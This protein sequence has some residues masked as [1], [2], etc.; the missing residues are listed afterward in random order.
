MTGQPASSPDYSIL[1]AFQPVAARPRSSI[2]YLFSLLLVTLTMLLLPLIYLAMAGAAAYAVYYHATHNWSV[3]MNM[4]QDGGPLARLLMFLCYIV[5]VFAGAAMVFFILKPIFARRPQRAQPL[6]LNPADNPLLYA[7]IEK[8]CDS[9]GAPSP[10]RIDL[11]CRLNASVGFRRGF[12][13]MATDDLVLTIGLPFVAN[14]TAEE[15]TGVVAHEF[16][17]FNQR[18]GLRLSYL[19]R[20]V[21]IWFIRVVYQRDTWDEA[22][23]QWAEDADKIWVAALFW[24]VQIAVF[25]ERVVLSMLMY[26]GLLIGGFMLRQMEYD[27]DACQIRLVGSETF[28]RTHRK[29]AT[30]D[31]AA[32]QMG[33]QMRKLW[34][35]SRQLPD[36]ICE[37]LLQA[38][39]SLPGSVID[40]IEASYGLTRTSLFDS[41]PS[42]ADRVRRARQA[43][44][45]GA[46]HDDRPAS[47]L[48]TSFEHPARFVTMLHY[49]DELGIPVTPE[50]LV[51]VAAKGDD[52][53]A[54]RRQTSLT[55]SESQSAYFLGVLPLILP[56]KVALPPPSA[57]Y[58]ADF[59]ELTQLTSGLLQVTD[60][61]AGIGEQY[62]Q[63]TQQLIQAR[64]AVRLLAARVPIKADD[65]GLTATTLE[66]AQQLE[67]EALATRDSLRHSV[68]EVSAALQRRLR[69]GLALKLAD[70]GE[71][72]GDG[73]AAE[74]VA[75]AAAYLQA[76]VG[77]YQ[78]RQELSEAF[79]VFDR[80]LKV[81]DD[82]GESPMLAR[83]L[84]AQSAAVNAHRSQPA[85]LPTEVHAHPKAH[86]VLSRKSKAG[87][88]AEL[89][90]LR[91]Q[92][93]RWFADYQANLDLLVE[94]AQ[95]GESPVA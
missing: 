43:Q 9:V 19:I 66:A 48:F 59:A 72:Q 61:L 92:T 12:G 21:N 57:D 39:E 2:F 47:S 11:D 70:G 51:R 45:P 6:A 83:A 40:K 34:R 15:F 13:S 93:Q 3:L 81:R 22:L 17:H 62:Q 67:T 79:A 5:P 68:H 94:Y 20:T 8:I 84:A 31:A 38:R 80:I 37:L 86:L 90:G 73:S 76:V 78:S 30:L 77:D 74:R 95:A 60:Q 27:A 91:Q 89:D 36:N 58:E 75:H 1:S 32:Q 10:Q 64:A 50:M 71:L 35:H 63:T 18:I 87:V 82:E 55:A 24:I 65:F 85:F 23:R 14:L 52:A 25:C 46:F 29:L 53:G 33:R 41:H 88:A 56:L 4:A 44:D 28:E 54:N 49:T 16:G 26:V 69:Y 7:F 42:P